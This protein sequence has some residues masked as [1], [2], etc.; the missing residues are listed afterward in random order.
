MR[1]ERR[2]AETET[3]RADSRRD[4]VV[5]VRLGRKKVG[6]RREGPA[7]GWSASAPG[8]K[9]LNRHKLRT[10]T[11]PSKSAA[12][13]R[14]SGAGHNI[15]PAYTAQNQQRITLR[16]GSYP[17]SFAMS[18]YRPPPATRALSSSARQQSRFGGAWTVLLLSLVFHS[19]YLLSIFDIYF[20]SPV[21]KG[22]DKRFGVTVQDG[23]G[24]EERG[25][26][27]AKRVVLIVGQ[28]DFTGDCR[29]LARL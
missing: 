19:V 10:R 6:S 11:R 9:G 2:D 16:S 21:T 17:S 1:E 26:G 25:H 3:E 5:A 24:A 27:L 18:S 13:Q 7:C 29:S 4:F 22:V 14:L 20:K 23:D 15:A 12:P 28:S 8:G